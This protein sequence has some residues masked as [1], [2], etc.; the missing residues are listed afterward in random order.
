M[1][2]SAQVP[3]CPQDAFQEEYY[4]TGTFPG[5]PMVPPRRPW[6]LL[7][8]LFWAS[9]LLYPFFQFL[10]NM[11]SSGSS[12]TLASFVLVFFVGKWRARGWRGA[13]GKGGVQAAWGDSAW[14]SCPRDGSTA[15][16]SP[17][18]VGGR[19]HVH[20]HGNRRPAGVLHSRV[21]S[22]PLP[23]GSNAA[24]PSSLL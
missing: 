13:L 18:K 1:R 14:L 21:P 12:L 10:V 22:L 15:C 11:V 7:N 6:T 8:W 17:G 19:T 5:T 16:R 23:G 9:L 20:T 2:L 3:V 4:R 24:A